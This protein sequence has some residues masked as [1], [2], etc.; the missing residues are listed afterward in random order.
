M[1]NTIFTNLDPTVQV[2]LIEIADRHGHVGTGGSIKDY[3]TRFAQS[4]KICVDGIDAARTGGEASH[5][6]SP[7]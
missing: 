5:E 3:G 1:S 7:R 2:K 6:P 4:L